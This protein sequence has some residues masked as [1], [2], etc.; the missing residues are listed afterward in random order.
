MRGDQ[1]D[2]AAITSISTLSS[3][4]DSAVMTIRVDAGGESSTRRA[5]SAR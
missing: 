2:F 5:R 3:G 4:C 1:G